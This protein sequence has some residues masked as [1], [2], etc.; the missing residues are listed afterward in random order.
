MPT[1]LGIAALFMLTTDALNL[2]LSLMPGLSAKNLMIYCIAVI[3]ALR[4]VVSRTSLMAAGQMQ[5]AFIA[6]IGYAIVTWLIAALLI[7]YPYYDLV[8]SGIKLK[9]EIGRAHV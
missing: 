4:M 6:Q 7:Q 2:D 1:I 3:L 9:T 5:G 8:D